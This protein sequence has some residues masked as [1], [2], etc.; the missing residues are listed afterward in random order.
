MRRSERGAEKRRG[1]TKNDMNP[2]ET[3]EHPELAA[4]APANGS[5]RSH[6]DDDERP[7]CDRCSNTG[8]IA[9][10]CGGDLCVCMNQGEM[11]C[12]KCGYD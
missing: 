4:L 8:Y 2:N 7:Y 9:C 12:P 10:H 6:D 11:P 3:P 5:A 1:Q